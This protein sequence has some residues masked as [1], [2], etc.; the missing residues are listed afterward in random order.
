M[1]L[2][3]G[4]TLFVVFSHVPPR[5]PQAVARV[6]ELLPLQPPPAS[7]LW[8]VI[9]VVDFKG[10]TFESALDQLASLGGVNIVPQWS[11]IEPHGAYRTQPVTLHLTHVT[12]HQALTALM[13]VLE[14]TSKDD[15]NP[16]WVER[17]GIVVVS[18]R[19]DPGQK[20]RVTRLYDVRDLLADAD[21]VHSELEPPAASASGPQQLGNASQTNAPLPYETEESRVDEIKKLVIDH[22]QPPSWVDSGGE[23]GSIQYWAGQLIVTQT[24]QGQQDVEAFL[25]L[26]RR[27]N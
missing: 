5:S 16:G 22:V 7:P 6:R 26:L 15:S 27:R 14:D 1:A 17:D 12:V 11:E 13:T 24:E 4:I 25:E 23:F 3:L 10:V 2:L 21:R 18:T 8:H 9:D 20:D 19:H